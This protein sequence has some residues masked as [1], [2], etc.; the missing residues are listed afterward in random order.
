MIKSLI[1]CAC[2]LGAATSY[3]AVT[4]YGGDFDGR[5]GAPNE[6]N[7]LL[8][9]ARTYDDF[10][11]PS[12]SILTAVWSNNLFDS[13]SATQAQVE[14]RTGVTVGNGGTLVFSGTFPATV[15]NTGR[16]GFG[17][18]EKTVRVTG[19]SVNLGAGTYFLSVTPVGVGSGR[20]FVSTAAGVNGVGQPLANGNSFVNSLELGFTF[21]S[22]S[23][24]GSGNWDF[25]MGVETGAGPLDFFPTT[26]VPIRG[27]L[28]SGN[29]ASLLTSDDNRLVHKPG[30]VLVSSQAP[31]A[32]EVIGT[33]P[34][35]SASELRFRIESHA[36]ATAISQRVEL[37]DY[38]ANAYVPFPATNLTTSDV[39]REVVVS[40]NA[41]RYIQA[42]TRQ[43]KARIEFRAT[44]PVLV[45]PWRSRVDL[46]MWRMTP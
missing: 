14:I 29:L 9:D 33:A 10:S 41:S 8:D 12:A 16:S 27:N 34:Q 20:S 3:A 30:V 36:S 5:N 23:Y 43:V 21:A 25:S 42:G 13:F 39:L 40:T 28:E 6:I 15:T 7:G 31:V 38:V 22:T 44:G 26:L 46:N 37:F 32:Y 45:Y 4:W 2:L 19:L 11:L 1:A 35:Q 24:L 17:M 18:D